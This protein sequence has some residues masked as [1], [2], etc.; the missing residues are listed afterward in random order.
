MDEPFSSY[1]E[2][3]EL[4]LAKPGIHVG[5]ISII[6]I[7]SYMDGYRHARWDFGEKDEDD[8]YN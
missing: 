5:D 6:R 2:L 8:L 7:K 3:F 1:S 4:L